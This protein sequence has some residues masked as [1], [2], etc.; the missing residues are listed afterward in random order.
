[1]NPIGDR[2]IIKPH[3]VEEQTAGGLFVV[4]SAVIAVGPGRT[5]SE[6]VLIKPEVSV[7]DVVMF[8]RDAG[9]KVK[10]EN[11]DY[12]I[13]TEEQILGILS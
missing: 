3:E 1:M 10:H 8:S 5:T 2:I 4:K 13:M 12:L 6:G 9:V 11:N 7:D